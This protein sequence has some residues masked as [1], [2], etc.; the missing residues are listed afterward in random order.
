M[1]KAFVFDMDGVLINSEEAWF[2]FEPDF[3]DNLFGEK[4]SQEIGDTIG[5][6]L[7]VI[8]DKAKSFGFKKPLEEI[9]AIW[10]ETAFRV[11]DKAT[12]TPDTDKLMEYL[13]G[14]S[15]KIGLVSASKTSW[16]N[17]VLPRLPFAKNITNVLS[18]DEGFHPNL[19]P[20]PSP[21]GYLEMM[22][23]MNVSPNNTII[24]EDSNAGIKSA[25]DAGAYTISL[26]QNLISGY[27]QI[28]LANA[29]AKNMLEVIGVVSNWL[30]KS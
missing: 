9:Q 25:V 14:E 26:S 11:Y 16:I 19:R 22:K 6:P 7:S 24:L 28:D 18:L 8:Y 17:R 2:K 21:D 4:I 3:L 29:K 5:I 20:K 1:S 13:I 23:I 30:K 10:D 15:F 27:K 12:I